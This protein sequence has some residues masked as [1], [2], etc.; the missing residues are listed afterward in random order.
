MNK[1]NIIKVVI[2]AT[3]NA[4]YKGL[5][6]DGGTMKINQKV[7]KPI[8]EV[9]YL[10][11]E[12]ADR[13]RVII[14]HFYEEYETIRYILHRED[15]FQMMKE[16]NLFDGYTE[17]M[18]QND[19]NA[20]VEWGNLI[21]MQDSSK[22]S[23]L[24]EFRNRRFRYQLSQY[25][26]E[27]ER[28][29]QRLENLEIEGA[30][31]EPTL[32]ERIRENIE[33]IEDMSLQSPM[34]VHAWWGSLNDDFIKLNRNY[35][36]YIRELS[37]IKADEMLKS[38]EF[39]VYKERIIQYLRTF[40]KGLQDEGIILESLVKDIDPKT[41][42]RLFSKVL[43]YEQSIPRIEHE[44]DEERYR[45]V[46]QGRWNNIYKWFVPGSVDSEINRMSDITMEI[47]RKITRYAQQIGEFFHRGSNRKEEYRHLV[48]IFNTCE[49]LEEAHQ[50]SAMVFGLESTFHLK[51][52]K[53]RETESIH[54]GVFEETSSQFLIHSR[55][56]NKTEPR[57]REA[58]FDYSIEKQ[59]QRQEIMNAE[60]RKK[61]IIETY[62]VEGVIDFKKLP[63]IDSHTRKTLLSW[64]SK[65]LADKDLK[66]RTEWGQ[67][68]RIDKHN[69]D[70]CILESEDGLLEM[71]SYQIIFEGE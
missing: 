5:F 47:I 64:L 39:V 69:L 27:I 6:D 48:R 26:I 65:G 43:E 32:L 20:L 7:L 28:M 35:Q 49:T 2:Y 59:M 3:I 44:F 62:V 23:S 50:L 51:G 13:Y 57:K 71:P 29:T 10:R 52:L 12:N 45:A 53:V 61:S 4:I 22:V 68:F 18:C 63:K 9:S 70:I 25:T 31:L 41:I 33:M 67:Y 38:K 21:A 54:S 19:L 16:T 14:R 42:E 36:D 34:Q 60:N 66:S 17:D 55:A 40:V 1:T 15:I 24:Q 46:L 11:A 30:S 37:G 8:T 56:R 58:A